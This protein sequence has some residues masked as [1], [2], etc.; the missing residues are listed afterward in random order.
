MYLLIIWNYSIRSSAIMPLDPIRGKY[1]LVMSFFVCLLT[2]QE[3]G[4]GYNKKSKAVKGDTERGYGFPSYA[5]LSITMVLVLMHPPL[6]S[7]G[8]LQDSCRQ[9]LAY[10]SVHCMLHCC[11]FGSDSFLDELR[12]TFL[13]MFKSG[14]QQPICSKVIC[15]SNQ[16]H[17]SCSQMWGRHIFQ[18][19]SHQ[20]PVQQISVNTLGKLLQIGKWSV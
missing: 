16:P 7:M 10:C 2:P 1:L 6:F 13:A 14:A 4:I 15:K 12:G 3:E 20:F 17:T 5:S 18:Y 8:L 11:T 9:G 19:R